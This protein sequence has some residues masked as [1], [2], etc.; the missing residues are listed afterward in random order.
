VNNITSL[1]QTQTLNNTKTQ[2]FLSL[3]HK[4][5]I[6]TLFLLDEEQNPPPAQW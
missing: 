2:I 6:E 4:K 3:H 5:K 1:S